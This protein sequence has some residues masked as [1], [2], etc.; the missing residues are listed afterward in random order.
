[1]ETEHKYHYTRE[2]YNMFYEGVL[3]KKETF[4]ASPTIAR[5]NDVISRLL[6]DTEPGIWLLI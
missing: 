2:Y 1:M 3:I 6:K 5:K 4:L